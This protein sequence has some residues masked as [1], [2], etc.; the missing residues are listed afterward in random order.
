VKAVA[1]EPTIDTHCHILPG[2]DDGPVTLDGAME[3]ARLAV[4]D[5]VRHAVATPHLEAWNPEV[6]RRAQAG[7]QALQRELALSNVSLALHSGAEMMLTRVLLDPSDHARLHTLNGTRYILIELPACDYPLYTSEVVFALQLRGLVPILAH[8]ERNA[9]IQ[10]D[11]NRLADLVERGLLSQITA[12]SL[13]DGADR[14]VR[15]CAEQMLKR[16]LA[17]L[18]ASDAHDSTLRGPGLSAGVRAAGR[19]LG[20]ERAEAMVTRIPEAIL[21]DRDVDPA[22]LAPPEPVRWWRGFR[23][24]RRDDSEDE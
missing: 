1:V 5:G 12:H 18:I 16:G 23:F 8:P 15:R 2:L 14:Q 13:L 4:A 10:D 19:I 11:L 22:V 6:C 21:A 24:L 20:R 9:A 17:H 3:M 7:V